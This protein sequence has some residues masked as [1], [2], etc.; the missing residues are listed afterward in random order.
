MI[1]RS[2]SSIQDTKTKILKAIGKLA[3]SSISDDSRQHA[4]E[5]LTGLLKGQPMSKETFDKYEIDCELVK[6]ENK[7][8][9][10]VV[11]VPVEYLPNSLVESGE[12]AQ[13]SFTVTKVLD[14]DFRGR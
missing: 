1:V 10:L 7:P 12:S 4:I 14:M 3:D 2:A 6:Q 9:I 13:V 11:T 5:E 8:E